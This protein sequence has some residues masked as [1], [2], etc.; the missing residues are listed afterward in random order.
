MQNVH[1]N[2]KKGSAIDI[3]K[4][5]SEDKAA[6]NKALK[7]LMEHPEIKYQ[8]EQKNLVKIKIIEKNLIM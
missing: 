7:C 1:F 6:I 2:F 4:A 3:D 8:K 5:F